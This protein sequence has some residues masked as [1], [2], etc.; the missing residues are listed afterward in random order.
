MRR[1]RASLV[2]AAA[3][4]LV[5][6]GLARAQ[7]TAQGANPAQAPAAPAQESAPAAPG[8]SSPQESAPATSQT[9]EESPHT[10]IGGLY[11]QG[12][13][14]AGVRFFLQKPS[15]TQ[16]GKFLEYRDINTGLF[17]PGLQLRLFTPDEKYS[18][19]FSGR[20]WGLAT[21]EYHLSGTRLGLWEG[22]FDWVG[23][24]HLYSSNDRT[25]ATETSDGV[26]KLPTPRPPLGAYGTG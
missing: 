17:L 24:R 23:M 8:A 6:P 11:L 3:L 15:D 16:N 22:G 20:D 5:V 19:E 21:Q 1:D 9:S 25:P 26:W 12:W 4:M 14:E 7:L 18:G 13:A 10:K 2:L